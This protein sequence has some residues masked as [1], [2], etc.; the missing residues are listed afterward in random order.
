MAPEASLLWS[1]TLDRIS[2]AGVIQRKDSGT[3]RTDPTCWYCP[4]CDLLRRAAGDCP[5]C[6]AA[7][8]DAVSAARRGKGA[9]D[10]CV[11]FRSTPHER[12]AHDI[13]IRDKKGSSS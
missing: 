9:S 13:Q 7:A 3:W 4:R 1:G 11:A 10:P 12:D 5:G 8:P 2:S 6:G